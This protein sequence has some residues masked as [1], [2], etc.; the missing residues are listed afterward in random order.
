MNNFP[1]GTRVFFW[2]SEGEVQYAVVKSSSR[3][4][5]GTQILVLQLEGSNK[6]ITL[7]ALGVTI[8]T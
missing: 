4:Q 3:L 1:A 5:D 7:P 2:T 8:V 6:T